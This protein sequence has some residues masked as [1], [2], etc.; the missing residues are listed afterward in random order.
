MSRTEKNPKQLPIV[1]VNVP[2]YKAPQEKE[3]AKKDFVV[4]KN[5]PF[6]KTEPMKMPETKVTIEKA[7]KPG[8]PGY[9]GKI[10]S[11]NLKDGPLEARRC[12]DVFCVLIFVLFWVGAGMIAVNSYKSV[13]DVLSITY[14]YDQFGAPLKK[15]LQ[16]YISSRATT[17]SQSIIL[18]VSMLVLKPW[19]LR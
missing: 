2:N 1:P 6:K 15:I 7:K 14:V 12:T 9:K 4:Q 19:T 16:H 11:K 8:E 13:D 5:Q 10:T 18:H 3:N 17:N